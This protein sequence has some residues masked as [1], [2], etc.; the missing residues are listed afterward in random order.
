[1]RDLSA[2]REVLPKLSASDASFASSL[3]AQ[4]ARKGSLSPKQ[5]PWVDKLVERASAPP[6]A[7]GSSAEI[8]S[9]AGILA[10]FDKAKGKLK[11]PA[12]VLAAPELP[13]GLRVNVAGPKSKAPG[14]LNVM[15]VEKSEPG[16]WGNLQRAYY[17]RVGLDGRYV[18]SAKGEAYVVS[19]A[20]KLRAFSE[21]PAA[22]AAEYGRLNGA[23]CFCGLKLED[24][25]S[26]AVGYGPV[27]A[28]NWGLPWGAEKF[29]F[30]SEAA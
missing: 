21:A 5:W 16:Q 1:M 25:R 14:S 12:I 10:L 17:G 4:H 27:C 7:P 2:L 19:I 23:C 13:G 20:A 6:K 30:V 28:K 3:L 22:V 26:V 9:L 18:S 29:S 24:E 15:S 11:Y 8:G